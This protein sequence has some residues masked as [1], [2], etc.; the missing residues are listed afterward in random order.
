[1][2]SRTARKRGNR[3]S[4]SCVATTPMTRTK[5][6]PRKRSHCT[7][8]NRRAVRPFA[9]CPDLDARPAA[10]AHRLHRG[11]REVTHRRR[12]EQIAR[13]ARLVGRLARRSGAHPHHHIGMLDR[14]VGRSID[15]H[16]QPGRR[17]PHDTEA[18]HLFECEGQTLEQG[19]ERRRSEGKRV[20]RGADCAVGIGGKRVVRHMHADEGGDAAGVAGQRV[21]QQIPGV[22][23][24][25]V[26]GGAAGDEIAEAAGEGEHLARLHRQAFHRLAE[27]G[28]LGR[29]IGGSR[30][31]ED[32]DGDLARAVLETDETCAWLE[33]A[34]R[35]HQPDAR[36]LGKGRLV[37]EGRPGGQAD[38]E[39]GPDGGKKDRQAKRHSG[40]LSGWL[41]GLLTGPE[42]PPQ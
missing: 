8:G 34:R 19:I 12:R 11:H 9:G 37:A 35:Q 1:M 33:V 6:L 26:D 17:H 13:K 20:Q 41:G 40:L 30:Q 21:R 42:G 2:P 32:G 39:R 18:G 3:L 5:A 7:R 15:Q 10:E 25:A 28:L 29:L 16:R 31:V 38:G 22:H 24:L 23:L 27:G 36:V 14:I 4:Q